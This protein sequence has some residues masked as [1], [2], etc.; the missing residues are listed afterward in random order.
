[1]LRGPRRHAG[2]ATAAMVACLLGTLLILLSA[3]L[4]S[5]YAFAAEGAALSISRGQFFRDLFESEFAILRIEGNQAKVAGVGFVIHQSPIQILTC[6]HVVSEG[7]ELNKG[8][9][10]YSIIRRPEE[11][12]EIDA[13]RTIGN[14]FRVTRIMFKP[15]YDLAILEIDPHENEEIAHKIRL[16]ESKPLVLNFDVTQRAV[17]SE[18]A[19]LTT[20]A[21][22]EPTLTPRL[23]IGN[24]VASYIT[25]ETYFAQS[26]SGKIA[27]VI[28]G[29]RIL[30]VDKL[31]L[32]GASG[33]PLLNTD[34]RQVVGYVQG[35]R[36]YAL[37]SGLN[38]TE[39][40]EIGDKS[41]TRE[42]LKF[43]PRLITSLSRAIDL[44]TAQ[45][46]FSEE[47]YV[48]K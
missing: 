15:E 14:F 35:Y 43:E 31:F 45:E 1:M 33:S 8:P 12:T 5:L 11:A 3:P 44:R 38:V 20:A 39:D 25:N 18:V 17:G 30:E 16:E 6:Y 46:F 21:E 10:V 13:R 27:R 47:G 32:P 48:T 4:V 22:G 40:V 29:A 41:L 19:W 28:S 2:A 24:I 7:T 37:N 34:T 36:A 23:F 9:I 42:K 26:A